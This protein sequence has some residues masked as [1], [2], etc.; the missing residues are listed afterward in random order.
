MSDKFE[1]IHKDSRQEALAQNYRCEKLLFIIS[2][3]V[4]V[5]GLDSKRFLRPLLMLKAGDVIG[6]DSLLKNKK[7]MLLY[8]VYTKE[9]VML[10]IDVNKFEEECSRH[11]ELMTALLEVQTER[12]YKFAK[13]WMM[14]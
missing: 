7:S 10:S 1:V 11:P 4:E 9:A 2:G 8:Q 13:L 12:M 14:A 3:R 6:V 5:D